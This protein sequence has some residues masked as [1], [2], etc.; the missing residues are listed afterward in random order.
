MLKYEIITCKN[1]MQQQHT[2]SDSG[3]MIR[4]IETDMLYNEAYDNIPVQY[5]YEETDIPIEEVVNVG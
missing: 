2:Y 3:F 4:Q 5:S 1:G